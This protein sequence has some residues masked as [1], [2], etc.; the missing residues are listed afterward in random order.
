MSHHP[1]HERMVIMA[2]QDGQ[3]LS[4][5]HHHTGGAA[6]TIAANIKVISRSGKS[7]MFLI[8]ITSTFVIGPCDR[9]PLRSPY[10]PYSVL[11]LVLLGSLRN[12]ACA[13]HP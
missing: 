10:G 2:L 9:L 8:A 13:A 5:S 7:T 3:W 11:L 6:G 12:H 1:A 4:P